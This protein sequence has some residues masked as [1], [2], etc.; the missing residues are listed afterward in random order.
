MA[1][2]GAT[3][4]LARIEQLLRTEV[5]GCAFFFGGAET[6]RP[7]SGPYIVW[8]DVRGVPDR[9]VPT[10]DSD[11]DQA[12]ASDMVQVTAWCCGG[13]GKPT[14]ADPDLRRSAFSASETVLRELRRA[15]SV[16]WNGVREEDP[17]RIVEPAGPSD[18]SVPI[19]FVFRVRIDVLAPRPD[20]AALTSVE[21]T[22]EVQNG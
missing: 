16:L 1:N 11:L 9:Y 19:E 14:A 15:V 10:P 6:Q 4:A 2:Q 8:K 18:S 5:Q 13:S 3:A 12:F 20:A 22:Y 17:W 7:T 21:P